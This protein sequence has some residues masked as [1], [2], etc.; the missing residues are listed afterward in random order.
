[1]TRAKKQK[2]VTP[3]RAVPPRAALNTAGPVAKARRKT[4]TRQNGLVRV[5]PT[6]ISA[7]LAGFRQASISRIRLPIDAFPYPTLLPV[8]RALYPGGVEVVV[9]RSTEKGYGGIFSVTHDDAGNRG[10]W[11]ALSVRSRPALLASDAEHELRHLIQDLGAQAQRGFGQVTRRERAVL[12]PVVQRAR[13][14]RHADDEAGPAEYYATPDEWQPLIGSYADEVVLWLA[15]H[16][17]APAMR[18]A[19]VLARARC[20]K[21]YRTA[22]SALK[23][24]VLGR[25]YTEVERQMAVKANPYEAEI[26]QSLTPDLLRPKHREKVKAGAHPHT[27]HCYSA[28]EACFHSHGGKAAG[29]AVPDAGALRGGPGQGLP[30]RRAVEAGAGGH[31]SGARGGEVEPRRELAPRAV[32]P[33]CR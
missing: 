26:Q 13:A 16:P 18:N 2:V 19:A 21:L 29:G 14:L 33:L 3:S 15:E 9:S 6:W 5:P 30:D 1:M 12:E 7:V 20:T 10:Y 28:S 32:C 27:G 23:S 17:V 25:I 24:Q 4:V 8:V 22:P 11:I 31:G